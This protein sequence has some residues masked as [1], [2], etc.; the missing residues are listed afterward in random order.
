M[1]ILCPR[2]KLRSA[3]GAGRPGPQQP[4]GRRTLPLVFGLL[5]ASDGIAHCADS[6]IAPQPVRPPPVDKSGYTLFNPTPREYMR[7]FTTDRPDLTESPFTVDAG[8]FQLEM[9]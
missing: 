6:I 9:D 8:H 3:R 4:E 7:A 5:L 1:R 2:P